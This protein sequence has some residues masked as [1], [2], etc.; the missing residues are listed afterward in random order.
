MRT[1]RNDEFTYFVSVTE[2]PNLNLAVTI[3]EAK[4]NIPTFKK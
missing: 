1:K 3:N 4:K 2:V